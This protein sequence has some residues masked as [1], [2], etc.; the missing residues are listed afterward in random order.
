[1]ELN[2]ITLE[3]VSLDDKE[4]KLEPVFWL[5]SKDSDVTKELSESELIPYLK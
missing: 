1:L 5:A 2:E 3:P 4:T